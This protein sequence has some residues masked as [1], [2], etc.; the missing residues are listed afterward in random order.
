MNKK[1][2]FLMIFLISQ[3]FAELPNFSRFRG[4]E[5]ESNGTCNSL[6]VGNFFFNIETNIKDALL[7]IATEECNKIGD[8]SMMKEIK[9]F[10]I[11]FKDYRAIDA[12]EYDLVPGRTVCA[13]SIETKISN[14]DALGMSMAFNF[15]IQYFVGPKKDGMLPVV[16]D[17]HQIAN[18]AED[19]EIGESFLAP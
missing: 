1:V 5:Q 17:F 6:M 14:P 18:I 8:C 12:K 15:D 4:L 11:D 16:L 19:I 7:M 10:K 3:V 9:S 2:L 13:T